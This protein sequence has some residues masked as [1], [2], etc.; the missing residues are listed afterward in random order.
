MGNY[1]SWC[2]IVDWEYAYICQGQVGD[3]LKVCGLAKH[4]GALSANSRTVRDFF[5]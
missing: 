5:P 4:L 3:F 1:S 2:A